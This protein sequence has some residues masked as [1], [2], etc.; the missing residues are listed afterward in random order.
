MTLSFL[1]LANVSNPDRLTSDSGWLYAEILAPALIDQGAQVT[2]AGPVPLSDPRAHFFKVSPPATKYRARFSPDIGAIASLIEAC[3]PT[4]IVV[5][6]LETTAAVR[7]ALI[8]AGHTATVVGYCHYVPFSLS[9]EG[10]V[11][12]DPSLN[13]GALGMPVLLAFLGGIRACDVVMVHSETAR[14][15]IYEAGAAHGLDL[16]THLHIVPPPLDPRVTRET[17][18]PT[19]LADRPLTGVYNH[20][21]Y[22]HYGTQ[23]FVD[24]VKRLD[25]L[26]VTIHVMDLFGTRRSERSRLDASPDR[27]LRMLASMSNV[28]ILSDSGDRATYRRI[29]GQADF[30]IAPFREGCTWSMSVVDCMAMGLPVLAPRMGWLA[31]AAHAELLF[32]HA[33]EAVTIV[34]R[35]V[36]EPEFRDRTSKALQLTVDSLRP[37]RIASS[38]LSVVS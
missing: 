4:V 20:R 25:H 11:E 13:D 26:P 18:E 2:F 37:D 12:K 3:R 19:P 27:Y 24:L 7:A 22:E 21:L 8:E 6:Q 38:Y 9:A 28:K 14:R 5:N 15:W 10:G 33:D 1:Y 30:G 32:D 36:A 23:R 29:L 35:L 34:E 17:D 31:E 16:S